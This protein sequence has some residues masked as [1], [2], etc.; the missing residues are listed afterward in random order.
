MNH[1]VPIELSII[2]SSSSSSTP[3]PPPDGYL[4]IPFAF[5]FDNDDDD[6]HRTGT[7]SSTQSK[8]TKHSLRI[9]IRNYSSCP[10]KN[11]I[12]RRI[13]KLKKAKNK[14]AKNLLYFDET[15]DAV[16][17][18]DHTRTT[19][20][21]HTHTHILFQPRSNPN[22]VITN[23]N[24]DK[25]CEPHK[26]TKMEYEDGKEWEHISQPIESFQTIEKQLYPT[27]PND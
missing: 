14:M 11:S 24:L 25:P 13:G 9:F 27:Y 12:E 8:H 18:E 22:F 2:S 7:H 3:P 5:A 4:E 26:K 10:V 6:N 16:H 17:N 20:N 15:V 19:A 23:V 21:T 1:I